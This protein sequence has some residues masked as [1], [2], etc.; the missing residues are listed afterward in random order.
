[1]TPETCR[2]VERSLAVSLV[3]LVVLVLLLGC[4]TPPVVE[5][6]SP[7]RGAAPETTLE[8]D[9]WQ[10]VDVGGA[11]VVLPGRLSHVVRGEAQPPTVA[12][13]AQG[14]AAGIDAPSF[15]WIG[16]ALVVVGLAIA[17]WGLW[18]WFTRLRTP[19]S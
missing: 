19:P 13:A 11:W 9:G 7:G 8:L 12:V 2:I 10:A 6:S 5:V 4:S 17:A 15:G 18:P 16:W 3:A 14:G 1:M